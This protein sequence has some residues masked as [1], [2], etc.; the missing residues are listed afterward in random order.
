MD[1]AVNRNI[2]T[3]DI[4]LAIAS[5]G[6]TFVRFAMIILTSILILNQHSLFKEI[7][8]I[9]IFL[10][11]LFDYYDGVIFRKSEI[12]NISYWRIKR[13]LLDSIVDRIIIQI[14][15][16][17]L[18]IVDINFLWI[19]FA[20][21]TREMILS[22]Y[23]SFYF[24]KNIMIYPKRRSKYAA[25]LIGLTVIVSL[26]ANDIITAITIIGMLIMSYYAFEEYRLSLNKSGYRF[27]KVK[28]N[29]I[30]EI[31]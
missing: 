2:R 29:N 12:N 25:I 17:S 5:F 23:T 20:I 16:I 6:I 24:K 28:S 18:L 13:R 22:G 19:Y 8:I 31:F 11:M 3:I 1:L 26:F 30:I 9:S 14:I 27:N 10:V 7:A 15:C 21:L 4:T